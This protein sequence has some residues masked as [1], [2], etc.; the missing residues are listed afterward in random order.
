MVAELEEPAT[1][2]RECSPLL[3]LKV[4]PSF[5]PF[6]LTIGLISTVLSLGTPGIPGVSFAASLGIELV[7]VDDPTG[8]TEDAE[9]ML[10]K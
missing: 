4:G 9:S 6:G 1:S 3:T 2:P 10:L 5:H 7:D 8:R